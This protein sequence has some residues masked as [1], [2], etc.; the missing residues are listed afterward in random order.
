M[1]DSGEIILIPQ[2][3]YSEFLVKA[4]TDGPMADL[5]IP[6][7]SFIHM[8]AFD[9]KHHDLPCS[10]G[11]CQGVTSDPPSTLK[12]PL[13][14][15]HDRLR[16]CPHSQLVEQIRDVIP[17]CLLANRQPLRDLCISQTFSHQRQHFP[18]A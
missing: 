1:E 9:H 11:D 10:A 5:L 18:F 16:A 7:S 17:D 3:A 14:R 12:P 15:K 13:E 2:P 8:N 4:D 6:F